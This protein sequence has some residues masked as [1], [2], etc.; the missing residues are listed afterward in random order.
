MVRLAFTYPENKFRQNNHVAGDVLENPQSEK[1][2]FNPV[3]PYAISKV[4]AYFSVKNYREAYGLFCCNGIL[5]NHE[6]PRRGQDFVTRKITT[7]LS[8]LIKG[9][10]EYISVGNLDSSRDWGHARDYVYGM[11]LMLQKSNADDY[12]LA[13]GNTWTVRHFI[14]KSFAVKDFIIS[15]QGEGEN[16]VGIDQTGRTVVRVN[17]EFYRPVEVAFLKGDSS[18][19]RDQLGWIPQVSFDSLVREMVEHDCK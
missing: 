9:K 18:K 2:P 17:P 19:A 6:S 1:T 14:E 7:S 13:T 3:S 11:W 8:A 10:I 5:F 16:E 4:F 15:W 12:V